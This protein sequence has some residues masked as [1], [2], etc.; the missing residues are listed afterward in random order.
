MRTLFLALALSSC[1]AGEPPRLVASPAAD[2]PGARVLGPEL[3]AESDGPAKVYTVAPGRFLPLT[4]L[5]GAPC[6]IPASDAYRIYS[7]KPGDNFIGIKFDA[8]ANAEPESY[9]WP[10]ETGPVYILLARNKPSDHAIQL[11]K[12]G[13][14]ETGPVP[15]GSPINVKIGQGAI[16]PPDPKPQPNPAPQPFAGKWRILIVEETADAA[17]NRGAFLSDKELNDYIHAKCSSKP[18]IV[19][20]DVKDATGKPP[21]DMVPW[22]NLAKGK[23]LPQL[24]VV[25]DDGNILW[26]GDLPNTPAATLA[27]L[28]A[29]GG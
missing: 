13:P 15:N 24:Y 19:D 10:K 26:Q 12:N 1:A 6:Y 27:V 4:P 14:P 25:A 3:K 28:K 17:N 16:P 9:S 22:L 2:G 20:Q 5:G 18:R 21:K 11:L 23:R 7:L 29:I 8:P